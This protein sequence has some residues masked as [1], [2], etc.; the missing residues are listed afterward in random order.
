MPPKNRPL[1]SQSVAR[2][3]VVDEADA[4]ELP[5]TFLPHVPMQRKCLGSSVCL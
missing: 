2:A 1:R 3:L 4:S 5:E